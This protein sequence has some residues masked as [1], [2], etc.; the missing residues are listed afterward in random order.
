MLTYAQNFEDVMLA[1]LFQA[2]S[3]GF[4]VDIGAWHPTELSVTRHFY[5]LGWSGI[6]I[7]PIRKQNELFAAERP[8]DLNL[9]V[10]VTDRKGS[11][12]FHECADDTALSTTDDDQAAALTQDGHTITS[13]DVET[14]TPAEILAHCEGRT[15]DFLKIDVEGCEER[16]VRS[17]DWQLFR[18]RVLVIEAT[19]RLRKPCIDWDHIEALRNW[20]AWEPLV[21]AAGY[22]FAC[23]DGLIASTSVMK[24]PIL[25]AASRFRRAY[26]INYSFQ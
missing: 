19:S 1:R 8:R 21:L 15:V 16:I 6:N 9:C 3:V 7:E 22:V 25:P 26:M 18:P 14:I 13:Y 23:Y 20:N 2:Q 11:L 12:R 17:V 10:A 24:T 5:D 4:Y